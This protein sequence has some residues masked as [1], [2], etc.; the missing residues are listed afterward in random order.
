MSEYDIL[1][2]PTRVA[3]Q[4]Y[5]VPKIV[6]CGVNKQQVKTWEDVT[7]CVQQFGYTK[8]TNGTLLTKRI[9]ENTLITFTKEGKVFVNQAY[10]C[11]LDY[12]KMVLFMLLLENKL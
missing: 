11:D 10:L 5:E 9:K 2:T 6:S 12:N 4:W 8:L 1:L 3:E 7:E